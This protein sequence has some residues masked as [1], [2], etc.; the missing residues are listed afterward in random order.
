MIKKIIIFTIVISSVFVSQAGKKKKNSDD[1]PLLNTKWV[2]KEVF[3]MFVIHELDTAFMIFYDT[4]KFSGNFGCNLFFG[5]YSYGK[6]RMKVDYF[7][8]TKKYCFDMRLEEQFAKALRSD[9]THY[10]IERDKLYLLYK[11]KVI[12]KFEGIILSE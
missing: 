5:E 2:L 11:N 1:L 6:K 12:C 8:A 10:F 7:G 4:Y 9:I 3:E